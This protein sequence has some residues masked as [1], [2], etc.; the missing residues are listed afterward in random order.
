MKITRIVIHNYKSIKSID[1]K[2]SDQVIMS[3]SARTVLAKVTS[4]Q[5]WNGFLDQYIPRS[6]I[7][8]KRIISEATKMHTSLSPCIL[9]MVIFCK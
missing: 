4:L 8:L 5:H 3:S 2:L 9:T 1:I 7:F 6:I